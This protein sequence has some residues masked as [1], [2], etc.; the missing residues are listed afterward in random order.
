LR[1]VA[2][3]L[4]IAAGLLS[5]NAAEKGPGVMLAPKTLQEKQAAEL[6]IQG[7]KLLKEKKAVQAR[8]LIEKAAGMW[9][10]SAHVHYNLACCYEEMGNFEKAIAEYE[11]TLQLDSHMT[12]CIPNIASCYQLLNR[13]QDAIT[14][15]ENYLKKRPNAPDAAEIKGMIAALKRQTRIQ[16]D[17]D[18]QSGDYLQSLMPKGCIQRWQRGRLPLKVFFANGKDEQ[19]RDVRGFQE[20]YNLILMDAFNT[21][22]K[23]SENRLAYVVCTDPFKADIVCTWT[24]RKDFLSDGGSKVEQGVAKVASL[25]RPGAT[26]EEIGHVRV[27][28][29]VLDM[30]GAHSISDEEMKKACLHEVGHAL[31]LAG[32]SSNNRD[33]MFFSD[34]PTIWASLTK[35][36]KATIAKLYADYPQIQVLTQDNAQMQRLPPAP[37]MLQQ[38]GQY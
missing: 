10:Q 23:A 12:D 38:N 3:A 36:D 4:C 13:P 28:I 1:Q 31:G 7:N 34:S 9:P 21:W 11:T 35:R 19:G 24:D 18:P 30:K 33:I 5:A 32:H 6:L 15:F 29:L 20:S 27:I 2:I 37:N 17:S 8:P 14:L 26:E 25:L 16:I 22:M